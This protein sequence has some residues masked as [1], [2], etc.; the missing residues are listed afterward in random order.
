ML[1]NVLPRANEAAE[2]VTAGLSLCLEPP[3]SDGCVRPQ[4]SAVNVDQRSLILVGCI[5]LM[6]LQLSQS[7]VGV[8]KNRLHPENEL[9]GF[10]SSAATFHEPNAGLKSSRKYKQ[11]QICECWTRILSAQDI[12]HEQ[13]NVIEL[14][15]HLFGIGRY[16]GVVHLQ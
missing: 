7:V 9:S 12:T 8:Q 16:D 3:L 5:F 13:T 11:S 14:S 10:R 6:R 2:T 4:P 1:K 15:L